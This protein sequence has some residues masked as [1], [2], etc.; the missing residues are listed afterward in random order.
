M[1]TLGNPFL[2]NKLFTLL[3]V[4]IRKDYDDLCKSRHNHFCE[5]VIT[6]RKYKNKYI[7]ENTN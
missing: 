7:I 5:I 6:F 1:E 2:K 3:V 4:F